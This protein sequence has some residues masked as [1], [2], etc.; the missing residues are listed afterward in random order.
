MFASFFAI[1]IILYSKSVFALEVLPAK[2]Y[3]DAPSNGSTISG[4]IQ[5]D[6]WF[7][8][9]S[10]VSKIEVLVDGKVVGTAQYGLSRPDIA[11]A[12]PQY[13]NSNSGYQY[14]L[15]TGKI[16]NGKHSLAVEEI[17]KNGNVATTNTQ[18]IDV[19]NLPAKGSID[20]PT[21]GSSTNGS[22]TVS[23]W[24]L[25]G[26][27]VSKIQVLVD[28]KLIGNAQ[29]NIARTDVANVFPQYNNNNS[30]YIC[31]FSI[32]NLANGQHTITVQETGRNGSINTISNIINK[33]NL[34]PTSVLLN[35]P[36]IAQNPE[37][38][39]GCE[40]T[41]LAMMLQYAG[42]NV[43]KMT[44]ANAIP[45]VPYSQNGYM[46]NPNVGF[47]GNM[48]TFSQ[49]GYGVYHVPVYNLAKRYLPSAVDLTGQSFNSVIAKLN[50]K[51]PVWIIT[52]ATYAPLASSAFVTW[53]TTSGN[54]QITWHEHS[55]LVTGYDANYIYFNDPLG[56]IK[57][58]K[59]SRTTFINAWTQM[60]SQAISY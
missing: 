21:N 42:V 36:L 54:V 34:S 2:G 58:R 11:A 5:V 30:G 53:K 56:V 20:T 28:R 47:V 23:G 41:S 32:A 10:G 59:I 14:T 49:S 17:S 19:Q 15:D 55:V 9:G 44:L 46:G 1:L 43:S 26:S 31:N 39:K 51:K 37:L 6:G 45:K 8:D 4:L 18:A 12:N 27:G 25:D 16:T 13:N 40:V 7:L 52:N 29:F 38:P 60:G 33:I 24:F 57:N 48:Y 35:A 22:I 50:Q 3:I